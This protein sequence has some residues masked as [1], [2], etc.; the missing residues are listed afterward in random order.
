MI[1]ISA[2][3]NIVLQGDVA[4]WEGEAFQ[5]R[6][7]RRKQ[8]GGSKILGKIKCWGLQCSIYCLRWSPCIHDLYFQ[9]WKVQR[10]LECKNTAVKQIFQYSFSLEAN[11]LFNRNFKQWCGECWP[12]QTGQ[13]EL[14]ILNWIKST[15][16]PNA[17]LFVIHI[18]K[19][20]KTTYIPEHQ[21]MSGSGRH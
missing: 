2:Q 3:L 9:S 6:P 21:T 15:F 20:N 5:L 17:R 14:E 19:E 13:L 7:K 10:Q 16:L 12:V 4:S 1:Y 11:Y 8:G 18:H